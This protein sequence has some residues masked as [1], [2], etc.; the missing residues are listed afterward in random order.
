MKENI[1]KYLKNLTNQKNELK[2]LVDKLRK[3]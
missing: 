3:R 2:S 1:L